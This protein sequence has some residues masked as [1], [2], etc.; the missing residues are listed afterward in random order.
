ML[1]LNILSLSQFM[2]PRKNVVFSIVLLTLAVAMASP[3][4]HTYASSSQDGNGDS[5]IG[6]AAD[7]YEAGWSASGTVSAAQDF[8]IPSVY[9][10][11]EEGGGG[12]KVCYDSGYDDGRNG[13]FDSEKYYDDCT[14]EG[15]YEDGFIDGCMS[16]EGN[17]RDT[18]N[19]ASED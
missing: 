10:S 15:E 8:I 13:S 2:K 17:T 9:A 14:G 6:R 3:L 18:C 1:F 19:S 16:V 5:H 7:G 4:M 11:T 12:K